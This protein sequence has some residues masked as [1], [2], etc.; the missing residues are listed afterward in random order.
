MV[1]RKP[2]NSEKMSKKLRIA[3]VIILV[4][5]ALGAVGTSILFHAH[6]ANCAN[7]YTVQ[8]GDTLGGIADRFGTDAQTLASQNGIPNINLIFPG[9]EICYFQNTTSISQQGMASG[10]V[11]QIISSVFG[12]YAPAAERVA[13]CESSLNPQATNPISIGGSH[14]AGLF[15][16]LY[17]STWDTTSQAGASPYDARANAQAAY[18]IFARDGFTWSE[19]VCQP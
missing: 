16:V 19:W 14:A 5:V 7:P 8:F 9:Q 11:Q 12:A 13:T 15:Q 2:V 17:P 4:V 10:S 1:A 3:T 6:A 18:E